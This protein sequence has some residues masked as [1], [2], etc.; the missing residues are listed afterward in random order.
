MQGSSNPGQ[1]FCVS[2]DDKY[3]FVN[4]K[5]NNIDVYQLFKDKSQL[6]KTIDIEGG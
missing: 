4:N 2:F 5:E 3:I 1:H 6:L